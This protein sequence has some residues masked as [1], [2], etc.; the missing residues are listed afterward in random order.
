M[1]GSRDTGLGSV[2]TAGEDPTGDGTGTIS[3]ITSN[4]GSIVVTNPNG[5]TTD[6][7]VAPVPS[8]LP[9]FQLALSYGQGASGN[10]DL[11]V[12]ESFW[13]QPQSVNLSPEADQPHEWP[14][15]RELAFIGLA[16]FVD[17]AD[18]ALAEGGDEPRFIITIDRVDTIFQI[19][20]AS[21]AHA[22]EL[23]QTNG[24]IAIPAGSTIGVRFDGSG[25]DTGSTLRCEIILDGAETGEPIP[26][27][28]IPTTQLV[29]D[30]ASENYT[31]TPA[32]GA[33][34]GDWTDD[35]GEGTDVGTGGTLLAH[36]PVKELLAFNDD[37]GVTF[38][39]A[40]SFGLT[41][42]LGPT[43]GAANTPFTMV[44]VIRGDSI[45]PGTLFHVRATDISA[46]NQNFQLSGASLPQIA[47]DFDGTKIQN[48]DPFFDL[49]GEKAVLMWW[50]DG[51]V[52]DDVHLSVNGVEATLDNTM[53]ANAI[54]S[55]IEVGF[56]EGGP[57]ALRADCSYAR[58]LYWTRKL[59]VSERIGVIGNLTERYL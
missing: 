16:V 11:E 18:I 10:A 6:L 25:V 24:L 42:A 47:M 27:P 31:V 21:G 36:V 20:L 39:R 46:H 34:H 30:L 3:E 53:K 26:P 52:G 38:S 29:L 28:P 48:T 51:G 37:A 13:F 7:S 43:W 14:V 9:R 17:D 2:P 50:S 45:S 1:F 57:D 54:A 40:N 22:D 41:S 44:M 8:A 32:G 55:F 12:G 56:D 19:S 58:V 4:D 15:V 59:T 23:L 49:N 35:S 5:P 33:S